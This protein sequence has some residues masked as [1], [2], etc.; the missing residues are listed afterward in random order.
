MVLRWCTWL[1]Y[2]SPLTVPFS[3]ATGVQIVTIPLA[4]WHAALVATVSSRPV[5]RHA[6]R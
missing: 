4:A 5:N 6:L 2:L 1:A 3:A